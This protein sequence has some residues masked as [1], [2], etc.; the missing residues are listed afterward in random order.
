MI[1]GHE[2]P[3][4]IAAIARRAAAGVQP[5]DFAVREFLDCWQSMDEAA[6]RSAILAEPCH[7]NRVQDAYL[8]AVAEH[9]AVMDQMPVPD[10][11][12]QSERFLE[13]PFF[14][15]GLQSLKAT[16]IVESPAAFRRR[17]IFISANALSRPRREFM[18]DNALSVSNLDV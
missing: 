14:A 12:E 8:A 10:W 9:L 2:L 17:L 11:T 5:F 7:L 1:T 4:S 3:D 15:G 18:P 6:K 13:A 16:L